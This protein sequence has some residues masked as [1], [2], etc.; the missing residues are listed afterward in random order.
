MFAEKNKAYIDP[1]AS[2]IDRLQKGAPFLRFVK[3]NDKARDNYSSSLFLSSDV[4][5]LVFQSP[6]K[7]NKVKIFFLFI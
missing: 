2:V 4:R 6:E 7:K 1:I 5:K 3:N